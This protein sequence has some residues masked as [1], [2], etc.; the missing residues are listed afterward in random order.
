MDN[1]EFNVVSAHDAEEFDAL[2][3]EEDIELDVDAEMTVET[4]DADVGDEPTDTDAADD[5]ETRGS[6]DDM[7]AV[8]V[9]T[10]NTAF[11]AAGES[12]AEDDIEPDIDVDGYA[13]SDG[14]VI[15]AETDNNSSESPSDEN[16]DDAAGAAEDKAAEGS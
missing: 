6:D 9:G 13:D 16:G 5:S 12:G 10:E 15:D 8:P 7:L 3:D 2:P 14:C 1:T 4:D 11:Y